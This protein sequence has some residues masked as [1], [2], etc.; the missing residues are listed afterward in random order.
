MKLHRVGSLAAVTLCLAASASAAPPPAPTAF[1]VKSAE[2]GATFTS[3]VAPRKLLVQKAIPWKT[4]PGTIEPPF[5]EFG[6]PQAPVL[7][8]E[9]SFPAEPGADVSALVQPLEELTAIDPSRGRPHL[10]Q[11]IY[12]NFVFKGVIVSLDVEYSRFDDDATKQ[13][14][15]VRVLVRGALGATTGSR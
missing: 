4:L 6:D 3:P 2:G 14:A 10:V 12:G 5:Q 1:L 9:L 8:V 11:A 15:T 13:L 7:T